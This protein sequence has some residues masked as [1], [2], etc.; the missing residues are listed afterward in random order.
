MP[1]AFNDGPL[2]TGILSLCEDREGNLWVGTSTEGLKR[3]RPRQVSTWPMDDGAR[4][5]RGIAEDIQGRLWAGRGASLYRERDGVLRELLL[6]AQYSVGAVAVLAARD[7]SVWGA[8][9][10]HGLQ[11]LRDGQRLETVPWPADKSLG[12]VQALVEDSR[13]GIWMGG[14]AGVLACWRKTN[15]V[16]FGMEAGLPGKFIQA[17]AIEPDDTLW[18]GTGGG[19]VRFQNGRGQ[20]WTARDGMPADS[21][22]SMLRDAEGV[23]WLGFPGSGLARFRDGR[24]VNLTL[25]NGLPDDFI[26]QIV[27]DGM[28]YL[29]FGCN[30]GVFRASLQSLNDVA[31]GRLPAL[32]PLLLGKSEGM[33][34][35]ECTGG[36]SPAGV[37]S[38]SGRLYFS[39]VKG[40]AIVDPTRF[41]INSPPPPVFLEEVLVDGRRS[42]MIVF[43]CTRAEL[44]IPPGRQQIEIHYAAIDLAAPS[45][46]RFRYRLS[47]IDP[48]WIEAGARRVANFHRLPPGTHEFQVVA[49][50]HD[51][52]W[53][54][55]GATLALM[56]QPFYWQTGW[57]RGLIIV[58]IGGTVL[59]FYER[60][61]RRLEGQRRIQQEF[62]RRLIESQ[63]SERKRIAAE[64]HDS[65]GQDL[66]LIK[67]RTALATAQSASPPVVAEQLREI[68]NATTRAIAE[69][70][71]ISY[72][73][74]PTALDQVGITKAIEWMI[75]KVAATST[76]KFAT[77]LESIDGLL[78]PDQEI[79]LYRIVQ[80][81]LNNVLKH[82]QATQVILEV[83]KEPHGLRVSVFDNGRGFDREELV[84][85]ARRAGPFCR[86]HTT[87]GGGAPTLPTKLA[88]R[89]DT[90]AGFGLAG[91][92]ERVKVL[93]GRLDIQSTP[94]K[95]TRLTVII[96]LPGG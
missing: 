50:K 42:E 32:H 46:L 7:G 55:N 66:L 56:V 58:A 45:G 15:F 16:T 90:P 10:R 2:R 77:E 41:I 3:F 12:T 23:L 5:V 60:R 59:G 29:W 31:D 95:G 54:E 38:R 72:A 34:E 74:R 94:G 76:T 48:T 28:G 70:R 8:D 80:E 26:S 83:R 17:F 4:L 86:N 14:N 61:V 47:D 89:S 63:E 96:P 30:R 11:H 25:E 37:R 85:P 53:N 18:I 84:G 81:S 92:G 69:A 68:S 64:I 65:L 93:G 9:E 6:P 39:T 44:R 36:Y 27:D 33:I 73:L 57:F 62:A 49:A 13:G 22:R 67:N 24:F 19:L 71:N 52:L 35:I 88:S 75:E 82:A 20:L 51:G 1:V 43:P 91:I 40:V 21:V 79:S 87:V 78:P